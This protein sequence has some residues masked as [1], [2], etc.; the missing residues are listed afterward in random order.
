MTA[1]DFTHTLSV[2]LTDSEMYHKELKQRYMLGID[3]YH[4]L[5]YQ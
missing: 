1:T 3:I 2:K 4:I 5:F